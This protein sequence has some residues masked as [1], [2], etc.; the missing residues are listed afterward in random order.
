[1]LHSSQYEATGSHV[2][3]IRAILKLLIY[4]SIVLGLFAL[5]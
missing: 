5:W 4:A 1:M 2:A 3:P